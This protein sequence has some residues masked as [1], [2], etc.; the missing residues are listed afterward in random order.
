M[1]HARNGK[2]RIVESLLRAESLA[3]LLVAV[4]NSILSAIGRRV[5]EPL[6][7]RFGIR[8]R[9]RHRWRRRILWLR[10]IRRLVDVGG[11]LTRVA[12]RG[13]VRL[14]RVVVLGRGHGGEDICQTDRC[15]E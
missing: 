13:S 6:G 5:G 8:C 7:V 11:L 15:V 14:V 10:G 9:Y 3:R 2:E 1:A 4:R 12:L